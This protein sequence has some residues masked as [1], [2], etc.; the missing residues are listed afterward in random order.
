MLLAAVS[1][2][3]DL[4]ATNDGISNPSIEAADD[5][6]NRYDFTRAKTILITCVSQESLSN[7]KKAEAYRKLAG[8]EWKLFKNYE[9]AKNYYYEAEKKYP[10]CSETLTGISRLERE[11]ENYNN[12]L[13]LAVH[14]LDRA[15]TQPHKNAAKIAFALAAYEHCLAALKSSTRP[16]GS[17]MQKASL[18]LQ[19][20]LESKPG[21]PQASKLL[22]GIA[23][24]QNDGRLA[25][26]AWMSYYHIVEISKINTYLSA[27]ANDISRLLADW[28]DRPLTDP[29]RERLVLLLGAS[30]FYEY[31]GLVATDFD[32]PSIVAKTFSPAVGDI[33]KY[34]KFS[35]TI[36]VKLNEYY[37]RLALGNK[38]SKKMKRDFENDCKQLWKNLSWLTGEKNNYSEK[39]FFAEIKD[40]FG[41]MGY[42]GTTSSGNDWEL[43]L[44]H[45]VNKEVRKVEQY[46]YSRS[47]SFYQLDNFVSIGF[48]NWFW[49]GGGTGGWAKDEEIV[50]V[51]EV[52]SSTPYKEWENITDPKTRKETE[53]YIE[54]NLFADEEFKQTSALIKKLKYDALNDIYKK[55]YKQGLRDSAL[56]LSFI[57]EIESIAF[58][59]DMIAHEGRHIIDRKCTPLRYLWIKTF[60]NVEWSAKLSEI[61]FSPEPRLQLC[62]LLSMYLGSS[63]GKADKLIRSTLIEWMKKNTGTIN[64]YMS[65]KPLLSQAYLLSNEQI[66]ECFKAVD[67]LYKK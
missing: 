28:H 26:K 22:L 52:Y 35:K 15:K 17:I 4:F 7:E 45:I 40:H 16:D 34:S 36:K 18:F 11:N 50:Q 1:I 2:K 20:V 21:D 27:T 57:N 67:P 55:L 64:G 19:E 13:T 44:G 47:I 48:L 65:D 62:G 33:V 51:K 56:Q 29:E 3:S 8:I 43:C 49:E 42:A 24:L 61:V 59:S 66:R 53:E 38:D 30:R 25:L 14:S 6:Y 41:A 32:N 63:H 60:G 5:A 58:E 37:R 9:T 12:A 39:K 23:L 46:G 31:A 54:K 10:N